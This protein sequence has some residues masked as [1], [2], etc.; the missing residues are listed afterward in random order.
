MSVTCNGDSAHEPVSHLNG[1]VVQHGVHVVS[2]GRR[3][4]LGDGTRLGLQLLLQFEG[5]SPHGS[6]CQVLFCRIRPSCKKKNKDL[7]H[8]FLEPNVLHQEYPGAFD[9]TQKFVNR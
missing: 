7:S 1:Q 8:K 9:S 5:N 3:R 4:A 6:R 2:A